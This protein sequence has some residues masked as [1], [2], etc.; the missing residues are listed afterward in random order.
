[1]GVVKTPDIKP[2]MVLETDLSS[3]QGRLLFYKGCKLTKDHV[4]IIKIWGV[5]EALIQGVSQQ[6]PFHL[7][8][9]DIDPETFN[10][11]DE[12]VCRFFPS[13]AA[14]QE[15]MRE[16][17]RLCLKRTT[18][19]LAEGG[20]LPVQNIP[21]NLSACRSKK[22]NETNIMDPVS[23]V[24]Q[25][26]SAKTFS[27][28]YYTI[29][30]LLNSPERSS[31]KVSE[32]ISKDTSLEKIL[33]KLV[34]SPLYAFPSAIENINQAV[35]NMG[36]SELNLLILGISGFEFFKSFDI[37]ST[38]VHSFWKHAVLCGCIAKLLAGLLPGVTIER[39]F[40][41]GLLHDIGKLAMIIVMPEPYSRIQAYALEQTVAASKAEQLVLGFDH[42]QLGT[43]L[44]EEWNVPNALTTLMQYH[45]DPMRADITLE[46]SIIHLAD[47]MALSIDTATQTPRVI[48]GIL[49]GVWESLGFPPSILEPVVTQAEDHAAAI[50]RIFFE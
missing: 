2:G 16:I 28:T 42:C 41:A 20:T 30:E 38:A 26:N 12:Y 8:L 4:R 33:L 13:C 35:S 22:R 25:I 37:P 43:L 27:Q 6:Q 46:P 19:H 47:I 23:I 48:P 39:Y 24:R 32:T 21:G 7:N 44:L 36:A 17:Y 50:M 11:S 9:L 40:V 18:Q 1:M 29:N 45:H 31:K 3:P 5:P 10:L 14:D 34:N 15:A 49:P